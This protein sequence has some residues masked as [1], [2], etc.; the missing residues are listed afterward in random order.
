MKDKICGWRDEY[1]ESECRYCIAK[2]CHS[3]S[4]KLEKGNT[5]YVCH[6]CYAKM[7]IQELEE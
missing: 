4:K 7:D 6:K 5:S 2:I 1:Y 3:C